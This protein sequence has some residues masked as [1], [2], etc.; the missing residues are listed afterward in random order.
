MAAARLSASKHPIGFRMPYGNQWGAAHDPTM[1][2][3]S[4]FPVF[5]NIFAVQPHP[6]IQEH[7]S[8]YALAGFAVFSCAVFGVL[9]AL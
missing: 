3:E 2:F 1:P 8:R 5:R 9:H 4:V 7:T 6:E